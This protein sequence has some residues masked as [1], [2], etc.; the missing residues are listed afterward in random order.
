MR[1]TNAASRSLRVTSARALLD[2]LQINSYNSRAF[3]EPA[4]AADI[5]VSAIEPAA[6]RN[7][8]ATSSCLGCRPVLSINSTQFSAFDKRDETDVR[9]KGHFYGIVV[10]ANRISRRRPGSRLTARDSTGPAIFEGVIF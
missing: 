7:L 8:S 6:R 2:T 5:L 3:F 10:R 9:A 1:I 4:S